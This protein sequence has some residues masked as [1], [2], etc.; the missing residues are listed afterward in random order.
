MV[1]LN[2]SN[3]LVILRNA[4]WNQTQIQ[5]II[6]AIDARNQETGSARGCFLALDTL[7]TITDT[8]IKNLQQQIDGLVMALSIASGSSVSYTTISPPFYDYDALETNGIGVTTDP[9]RPRYLV[10]I[11]N[12]RKKIYEFSGKI[13]VNVPQSRLLD[14]VFSFTPNSITSSYDSKTNKY[15]TYGDGLSLKSTSEVNYFRDG[16][17]Q[18]LAFSF[19]QVGTPQLIS[20]GTTAGSYQISY[21]VR[22]SG[23][24]STAAFGYMFFSPSNSISVLATTTTDVSGVLD[25]FLTNTNFDTRNLQSQRA[26]TLGLDTLSSSDEVS[27]GSGNLYIPNT[28]FK[29]VM[30]ATIAVNTPSESLRQVSNALKLSPEVDENEV[31]LFDFTTKL[32]TKASPYLFDLFELVS[33]LL[34]G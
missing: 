32:I 1:E 27:V 25:N 23:D 29:T 26:I 22:W 16:T 30:D 15:T 33:I 4:G 7:D 17:P 8:Q 31:T 21:V 11:P 12:D 13:T 3:S 14:V 10:T 5:S 6:A 28:I 34:I 9:A 19:E 24:Y 20:T 2:N 18:V